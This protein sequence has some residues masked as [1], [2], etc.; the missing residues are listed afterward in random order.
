MICPHCN[1]EIE[2]VRVYTER[3]QSGYLEGNRIVKYIP[4]SEIA[5]LTISIECPECEGDLR[6]HVI[7]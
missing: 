5:D 3:W 7:E 2:K 4:L 1:K 6:D